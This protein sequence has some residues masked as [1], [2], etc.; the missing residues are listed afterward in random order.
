MML[1]R[2]LTNIK[3]SRKWAALKAIAKTAAPLRWQDHPDEHM[4]ES[5]RKKYG[6]LWVVAEGDFAEFW[7]AY[8]ALEGEG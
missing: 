7:G 3:M 1:A 5:L 6:S 2:C 4:P 8:R